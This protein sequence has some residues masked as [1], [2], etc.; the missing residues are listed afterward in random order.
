MD[1]TLQSKMV[2]VKTDSTVLNTRY[3]K[4]F[5]SE[6]TND[7]MFLPKSVMVFYD[8]K[9]AD[10]KKELLDK[11]CHEYEQDH[12]IKGFF[13]RSLMK[14]LKYP[15]KL[16][17]QNPDNSRVQQMVYV[18]AFG[19]SKV[20]L[21]LSRTNRWIISAFRTKLNPY[22]LSHNDISIIIDVSKNSAI[23]KLERMLRKEQIM[24]YRINF[25]YDNDFLKNLYSSFYS[26]TFN[27]ERLVTYDSS[28]YYYQVLGCSKGASRNDIKKSYRALAK[29]Y[30]PDRVFNKDKKT[31]Q[32]YTKKFQQVQEAY[33]ALMTG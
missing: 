20:R 26:Y 4:E 19:N 31:V 28:S 5:I 10:K 24:Q 1:I 15:L 21:S 2:V 32:E 22:V 30:H 3:V 33:N 6:F 9:Q 16:E 25:R 14:Y 17:I 27:K 11:F 8:D 23:N 18:D 13:L 12:M 29:Q 7:L